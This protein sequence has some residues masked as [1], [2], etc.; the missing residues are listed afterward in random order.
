MWNEKD[1]IL[2]VTVIYFKWAEYTVRSNEHKRIYT[3]AAYNKSG[4]KT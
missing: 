1:I 3:V 2:K 4:S